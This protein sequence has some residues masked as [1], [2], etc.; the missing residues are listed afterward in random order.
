MMKDV[1][2]SNTYLHESKKVH[3]WAEGNKRQVHS[4]WSKLELAIAGSGLFADKSN[5]A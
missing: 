2:G 3:E 4:Q 5:Q 1:V